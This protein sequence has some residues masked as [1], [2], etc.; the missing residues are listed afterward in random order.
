MNQSQV[1]KL[2]VFSVAI[3]LIVQHILDPGRHEVTNAPDLTQ[4]F[5][6]HHIAEPTIKRLH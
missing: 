6:A 1:N 2:F 3:D 4:S 5:A